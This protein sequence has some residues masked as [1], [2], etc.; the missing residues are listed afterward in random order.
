M[1]SF[2][3]ITLVIALTWAAQAAQRAQAEPLNPHTTLRFE[4]SPFK[5]KPVF[6]EDDEAVYPDKSDFSILEYVLMSSD[7]GERFALI[8]LVNKSAGQRIFTQDH[9]VAILGNCKTVRPMPI[10]KRFASAE[11]LTLRVAFGIH[12]F[13]I[14]KIMSADS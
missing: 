4:S 14:L 11:T 8:T 10:E 6:C 9:V 5:D 1:T 12:K 3:L 7:S 2:K 13:P